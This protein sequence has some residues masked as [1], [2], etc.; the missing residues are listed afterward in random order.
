MLSSGIKRVAVIAVIAL[1]TVV[2]G[3]V[4][5]ASAATIDFPAGVACGFALHLD[6][7]ADTRNVHVK[8]DANGNVRTLRTGRGSTV[9]LTN[10]DTGKTLSLPSNGAVS[11]T[12]QHPDGTQT[13]TTTGHIIWIFFPT[14][15][16]AGPSTTLYV[17]RTVVTED[18][19][20]VFRLQ[21]ATGKAT[22]LCAALSG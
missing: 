15:I 3:L 8:T 17:G 5:A 7:G 9:T 2:G 6:V 12:V 4:D 16:P 20:G 22:D 18:Q 13:I 14:D 19:G 1:A 11:S 21:S 10:A